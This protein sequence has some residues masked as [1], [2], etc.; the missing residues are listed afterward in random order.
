M[1][2]QHEKTQNLA[3]YAGI[4]IL[5][6]LSFAAG[7]L[8]LPMFGILS[9]FMLGI[10]LA[11]AVSFLKLKWWV[12]LLT[13]SG[14]PYAL[15]SVYGDGEGAMP[16]VVTGLIFGFILL[17]ALGA[18]WLIK[19]KKPLY[20]A[21]AAGILAG[22]AVFHMAFLGN[23]AAAYRADQTLKTYFDSRYEKDTVS[24]SPTFYDRSKG[25]FGAKIGE[26]GGFP[27]VTYPVYVSGGAVLDAF[28]KYAALAAM[29]EKRLQIIETLRKTFPNAAF[30]VAKESISIRPEDKLSF[31]GIPPE[32]H[33]LWGVYLL[34]RFRRPVFGPGGTL[35]RHLGPKRRRR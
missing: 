19:K 26:K 2:D 35:C 27:A 13:F 5:C 16:H 8:A 24:F 34:R 30:T 11:F 3:E 17:L 9:T 15:S 23:P 18:V 22:A 7:Y 20:L 29:E 25:I 31:G 28:E 12:K 21:A 32:R 33:D 4:A 1:N 14:F 10:P 6:V